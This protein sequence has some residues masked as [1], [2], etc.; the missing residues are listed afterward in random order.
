MN[1]DPAKLAM[2]HAHAICLTHAQALDEA[3]ED[4]NKH[5]FANKANSKFCWTQNITFD[6]LVAEMVR[7]DL[8]AA[9]RDELIKKSGYKDM[10][11]HE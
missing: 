3:L 1:P 10:D 4:L 9:E 2:Q 7:G 11:Y 5:A 8:K 6:D